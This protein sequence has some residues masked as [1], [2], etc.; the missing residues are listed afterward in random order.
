MF[1]DFV[2]WLDLTRLADAIGAVLQIPLVLALGV[3]VFALPLVVIVF[4]R[5][6]DLLELRHVIALSKREATQQAQFEIDLA[7][8][9][10]KRPDLSIE[11]RVAEELGM[12]VGELNAP[13]GWSDDSVYSADGGPEMDPVEAREILEAERQDG[14]QY[15]RSRAISLADGSYACPECL[16][17]LDE[18][19]V[20][21][22]SLGCSVCGWL[23]MDD[24][25]QPVVGYVPKRAQNPS[26]FVDSL[27][28]ADGNFAAFTP[29]QKSIRR[30]A[31]RRRKRAGD[32]PF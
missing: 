27:Y 1:N 25:P 5:L 31:D 7:Q 16:S 13:G 21:D 22:G 24:D 20:P 9:L 4:R 26:E 32:L 6:Y 12:S 10:L 17:G 3:S 2:F 28:D 23:E 15:G 14:G 30:Q 19:Y 8:F 18:E 11:Q 29:T